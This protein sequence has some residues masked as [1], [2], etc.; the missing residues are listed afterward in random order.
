LTTALSKSELTLLRSLSKSDLSDFLRAVPADDFD[1]IASQ[2]VGEPGD[3][4]ELESEPAVVGSN[5]AETRAARNAAVINAKTAAAQEIGPLPAVA[6]PDRRA[7]CSANNMLFAETYFGP[8]FYL[9]WAPY[10]RSMMDRFQEV[11]LTGGREC[12]A[13]R[14]GGL[15]STCARVSTVWAVLNGHRRFPVLVGATDDKANEHRENFFAM[16]ASSPTLL[17]DYPEI[18]PLML[19]WRQPKRQFRLGGRL[20]AVH[21]K[22]PRGRIVFPD[23]HD[24][25]SCQAHIAPYSV[26]ATDVSGLSYVDR[27]GVTVRPDLLIFDDVQ[28]P[29]SAKSPLMTEEREEHITKTF[30]GLAGLGEKIAAIMVCTVREHQDL[31][32]HFLNRT[33]HPDWF[34]QKY[35]SILRMPDRMDL[36]DNYAKLLVTGE[37]PSEGKRLATNY[38]AH[39]R[40]AMDAGGKVAWEHDKLPDELSALQ[41]LMTVRALDASFFRCEIQQE[42]LKPANTSGLKLDSQSLLQRLSQSPR[43]IVPHG[44]SYITAFVDSS[45]QVLWWMVVAWSKDFSGSIVDYGTLPEQG[46]PVFY[47]SDLAANISGLLPGASWEEAFALAHSHVDRFLLQDWPSADGKA[48]SVDLILKDWSDG[49]QKPRIESQVMASPNRSRIRPS[50]GFAPRP[51]RKPVHLWGDSVRDRQNG[52]GWVERRSETPVH[53]QFNANE[54]K[55]HASRR[56]LTTVGAPSAVLLPGTDERENRLLAE[57]FTAETPKKLVYD[58]A[59]GVAW[60]LIPGRDNDWWD[61]FVGN[62]V[63]ASM[64]GC[65]LNGESAA[66]SKKLRTFALPGGVSRG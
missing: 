66:A 41:S 58:G 14:R 63:A 43:G 31:S 22:D 8:T 11:V 25:A 12:H 4:E 35:P 61:C 54:W 56:L 6:N 15:K 53:V 59:E 48:R 19:K 3:W 23:I 27:N 21:P 50:K 46:R 45:D 5:F 34:G 18:L 62:C 38:Y 52:N 39:N 10:Q 26:N 65:S 49:D 24:S 9:P 2:I 28:T 64:L 57:H 20:L 44:T 36:W 1:D 17:D 13:V 60:E 47:K 7:R 30:C 37:T 29:Q 55:S 51:G 32:E 42:G 40:E 33:R 16:L